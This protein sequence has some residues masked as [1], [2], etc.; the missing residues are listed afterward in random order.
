MPKSAD[1]RW[2]GLTAL[3]PEHRSKLADAILPLATAHLGACMKGLADSWL[4]DNRDDPGGETKK[5]GLRAK[6]FVVIYEFKQQCPSILREITDALQH[7]LLEGGYPPEYEF[8]GVRLASTD[9]EL[10]F[11]DDYQSSRRAL[12]HRLEAVLGSHPY[13]F[14]VLTR[15]AREAERF[16]HPN[17]APWSPLH[18]FERLVE[19]TERRF[20]RSE[21]SLEVARFYVDCVRRTGGPVIASIAQALDQLRLVED[22]SQPFEHTDVQQRKASWAAVVHAEQGRTGDGQ[23]YGGDSSE[24]PNLRALT[25]TVE[26]IARL[27]EG[28]AHL[29]EDMAPMS[30][31]IA[32]RAEDMAPMSKG[33]PSL[34]ES[35]AMPMED[36]GAAQWVQWAQN[37]TRV[38]GGNAG[39]AAHDSGLEPHIEGDLI[40]S[41]F[42]ADAALWDGEGEDHGVSSESQADALSPFILDLLQGM[43][44]HVFRMVGFNAHVR[45][46]VGNMHFALARVVIRDLGFFRDRTHPL[47]LWIGSLINIGLRINPDTDDTDNEVI[48]R[49]VE[50]IERSVDKLRAEA[51]TMDRDGAQ[52]LLEFWYQAI[53]EGDALWLTRQEANIKTVEREEHSARSWRSLARCVV[54]SDVKL[55]QESADMIASAWSE[56]MAIEEGGTGM[57]NEH[58]K[59]VVQAICR[60]ASPREVNPLVNRLVTEALDN[61]VPGDQVRSIV[62]NLGRAHVRFTRAPDDAPLFDPRERAQQKRVARWED[63]DPNLV[64]D[65]DDEHLLQAAQLRVGD[66]FGFINRTTGETERMALIWRGDA[67][68]SFLFLSLDANATRHHSLQGV[69]QE[70]RERRMR[71]LPH[72]N[73]LDALIQ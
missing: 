12:R 43:F 25:D 35:L 22:A 38:I 65:L 58:V 49:Y 9:G 69:A 2:T 57:L 42:T 53:A 30:K 55:T 27:S 28:I 54:E 68:R 32:H 39:G 34:G 60:N 6:D 50:C 63:D 20:E 11:F 51:E 33:M 47:R 67:T 70:L 71:P 4:G 19:A 66:W 52:S 37:M 15:A 44:D 29:A 41:G 72:D 14:S 26:G 59:G 24:A 62:S 45:A 61:G 73:A 10:V 46:A 3:T 18:W 13:A 1:A 56:V 23:P 40:P 36:A 7:E 5:S 16:Q 48:R 8:S 31:G 17:W 21:V 64:A